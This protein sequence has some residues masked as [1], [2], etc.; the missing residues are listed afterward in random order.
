MKQFLGEKKTLIHCD[1]SIRLRKK[2][3]F[4]ICNLYF[5][6]Y[7]SD[8]SETNCTPIQT[9]Y[10][11]NLFYIESKYRKKLSPNQ[12]YFDKKLKITIRL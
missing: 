4:S 10:L 8:R 5:K 7:K 1:F 11:K 3:V 6:E 12:N 2:I 9:K